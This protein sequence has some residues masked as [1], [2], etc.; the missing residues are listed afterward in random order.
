M[1]ES[2]GAGEGVEVLEDAADAHSAPA[3]FFFFS[4]VSLFSFE[5]STRG[6]ENKRGKTKSLSLSPFLPATNKKKASK[7]T[8]HGLRYSSLSCASS[9]KLYDTATAEADGGSGPSAGLGGSEAPSSLFSRSI[10]RLAVIGVKTP[11]VLRPPT[12]SLAVFRRRGGSRS[13]AKERRR[14]FLFCSRASGVVGVEGDDAAAARAAM[15][16]HDDDDAGLLRAAAAAQILATRGDL[17][18]D[19]GWESGSRKR[20]RERALPTGRCGSSHLQ[21]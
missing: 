2:D 4:F 9:V 13:R 20:E 1:V 5:V 14:R 12:M 15:R 3:F 16:P 21:N 11:I 6:E 19:W 10:Q 7:I 17:M 18:P 8:T